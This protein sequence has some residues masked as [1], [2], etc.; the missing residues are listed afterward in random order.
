MKRWNYIDRPSSFSLQKGNSSYLSTLTQEKFVP[1]FQP[2]IDLS[3]GKIAGYEALARYRHSDGNMISAGSLFHDL[4]VDPEYKLMLDRS[5]RFKAIE[6]FANIPDD[7]YVTL[8]IS[9]EWID[10]LADQDITILPT[11]EMIKLAGLAPSRVVIEITEY[12]G[13]IENLKRAV[14]IYQEVGIRVAIDDFGAGASQ[15]DRIEALEPDIVKLDMR[16]FKAGSKG[17]GVS[18]DMAMVIN[19]I[20]NR[21]GCHIVCEGVETEQEF[22]FGIECGC[23]HVQGWLF[24]KALPNLIDSG[25]TVKKVRDLQA[26]Y[27][28]SKS[29]V[30]VESMQARSHTKESVAKLREFVIDD[31]GKTKIDLKEMVQS[32]VLSYFICDLQG[33]QISKKFEV[34]EQGIKENDLSKQLNWSHRPYFPLFQALRRSVS[35]NLFSSRVY[36][37]HGSRKLCQTYGTYLNDDNILLVDVKVN[38]STLFINQ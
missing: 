28:N 18:A 8:N 6:K 30:L 14:K 19:S 17:E 9:P 36:R 32:G 1:F 31:S 25:E 4:N 23:S 22:F 13:D 16:L 11:L 26:K 24:H 2:I 34:T 5:V 37:D 35:H 12:R 21:L 38:D 7:S 10:R 20:A 15:I 3:S 33:T 27:L 29:E